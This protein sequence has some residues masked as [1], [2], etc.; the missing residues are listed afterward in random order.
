MAS[1]YAF[2]HRNQAEGESTYKYVAALREAA[3]YCEFQDLNEVLLDRVIGGMRDVELQRRLLAKTDLTLQMALKEAH[4]AEMSSRSTAK[5]QKSNRPPASRKPATVRH[6]DANCGE[7]ADEDDDVNC[8]RYPKGRN[9][10][11]EKWQPACAGCGGNH[12]RRVCRFKNAICY[13]C[14]KIGHLARVC[15]ANQPTFPKRMPKR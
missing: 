5:I 15:R 1:R 10:A 9:V 4:A 2:Y 11:T 14:E 13:R 12:P 8:L 6:E 3:L 7:S